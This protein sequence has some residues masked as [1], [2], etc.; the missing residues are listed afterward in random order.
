M[1]CSHF[2]GRFGQVDP[3]RWKL[4]WNILSNAAASTMD[5]EQAGTKSSV[6]GTVEN[7]FQR[8]D[9]VLI[10]HLVGAPQYNGH[11][12]VVVR[13]VPS[14]DRFKVRL[15]GV[16]LGAGAAESASSHPETTTISSTASPPGHRQRNPDD[17]TIAS[18]SAT[19]TAT[20]PVGTS[21]STETPNSITTTTLQTHLRGKHL[22][23]TQ[24]SLRKLHHSTRT[25]VSEALSSSMTD[26]GFS[27]AQPRVGGAA[28][29]VSWWW[30]P[31]CNQQHSDDSD[32]D[33]GGGSSARAAVS[34]SCNGVLYCQ[35][36]C[37]RRHR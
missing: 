23:L 1:Y 12:G 7:T 8:G 36:E 31:A 9:H 13:Y 17:I 16:A 20:S 3:A 5:N 27:R 6:S 18:Q 11:V 19:A 21:V 22:A 35:R 33:S 26:T 29:E 30:C 37:Q 10:E 32:G 15:L 24:R 14:R 34:C 4:G 2:G 28:F 25:C